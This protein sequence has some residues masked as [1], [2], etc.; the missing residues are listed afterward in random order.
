MM[1]T[2]DR[3][4]SALPPLAAVILGAGMVILSG[5]TSVPKGVTPVTGFDVQRYTGKWYEVARLD[6][7]FERGLTRVTAE[8][9]LNSNG[10]VAVVNRGW[11]ASG[12]K[13]KEA[14]G[15]ALFRGDASTGSLKVSF[16]GPFYGG[17]HI[18]ALDSEGYAYSMISG[19]TRS[20]LWLLSRQPT[21][22]DR[23]RAA[24]VNQARDLRFPVDRLIWV[25]QR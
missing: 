7:S 14:R 17:Y 10:T 11:D 15:R 3:L 21:L 13:W 18:V 24:L 9:T 1:G 20:Y 2:L 22:D 8:Y 23:V 5:C 4:V 19:P 25:D 16:F 6:H 12:Q